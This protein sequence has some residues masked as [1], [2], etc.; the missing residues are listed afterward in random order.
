M[1]VMMF[2]REDG[3]SRVKDAFRLSGP[4]A[5]AFFQL[6]F[7]SSFYPFSSFPLPAV[8]LYAPFDLSLP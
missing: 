2:A 8:A 6:T 5:P 1:M 7:S 3:M 4:G